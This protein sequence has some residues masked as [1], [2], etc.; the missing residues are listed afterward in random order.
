MLVALGLFLLWFLVA[1]T[2]FMRT[3]LGP[4]SPDQVLYHLQY[5][6]LD[7]ADPRM[8]NRALRFL[9]AALLLSALCTACVR[10]APRWAKRA[11]WLLLALGA[12]ASVRATVSE[13]CISG[14]GDYLAQ[15][16]VDPGRE[17]M[18]SAASPAQQPD[19]LI[20]FIESLDEAY[21]RAHHAY[22]PLL[23]QLSVL[24]QDY[25]TF[26]QMRNLSGASWTVGGIFTALCGVPLQPVGLLSRQSFEYA[27]SF[28]DGG[29]C[30]TDLLAEQ[31]WDVSFYGGASLKFAGKG[32]FFENHQVARRFGREEWQA[33]GLSFPKAGWGLLDAELA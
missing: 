22:R 12:A 7:Y 27:T 32:R 11:L 15:H 25:Q 9:A 20:V 1:A 18:Q 28:F 21:T 16:Y 8:L 24:Q 3:Y 29:K 6:G 2:W 17:Q 31:G 19:I 23:P 30:L 33:R 4:V 26:G 5:G 13:P 10:R 14:A